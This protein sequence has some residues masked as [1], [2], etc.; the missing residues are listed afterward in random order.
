MS[1]KSIDCGHGNKLNLNKDGNIWWIISKTGGP[2]LGNI[3]HGVCTVYWSY[4]LNEK[5]KD[6]YFPIDRLILK[7]ANKLHIRKIRYEHITN[8]PSHYG[9]KTIVKYGYIK[10][11]KFSFYVKKNK[12]VLAGT[13]PV[14]KLVL[15]KQSDFTIKDE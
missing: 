9:Q 5:T 8:V 1:H 6:K 11:D 4:G 14:R 2:C 7:Y 10:A 3:K 15:I 13:S 12:M